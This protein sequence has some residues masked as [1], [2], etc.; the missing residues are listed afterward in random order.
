MQMGLA[1]S[2][3]SE[4]THICKHQL[5]NLLTMNYVLFQDENGPAL[6]SVIKGKL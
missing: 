3:N 6:H 2:E 5:Y 4:S 1:L